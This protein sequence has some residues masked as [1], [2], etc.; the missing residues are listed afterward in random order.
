MSIDAPNG[1]TCSPPH[2]PGRQWF[3]YYRIH[4]D[5]LPAAVGAARA[6]QLEL[7][8]TLPG[9]EA[10]LLRR[11]LAADGLVTLMETYTFHDH[12]APPPDALD[13]IEQAA[14]QLAPWLNGQRHVEE[15]IPCAC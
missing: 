13:R 4:L 7:Q 10:G 6:M 2:S 11:P 1:L 12:A 15:F 5:D 3:I 9:L 8:R 14:R